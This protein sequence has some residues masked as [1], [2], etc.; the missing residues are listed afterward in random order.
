[1]LEFYPHYFEGWYA[2]GGN[3]AWMGLHLWYL[4]ILFLF[5]LLSLP[6]FLYLRQQPEQK[7]VTMLSVFCQKSGAIFLMAVP[8]AILEIVLDPK[9]LGFRSFGGWNLFAYLIFLY[10]GYLIAAREP[11][12]R[13]L[14]QNGAIALF[15]AVI[16]ALSMSFGQN[17]AGDRSWIYAGA[18]AL[19]AFNAWC[20]LVA[21]LYLG[22]KYLSFT[23]PIL[24]YSSEATLPVYML[25]Q[26]VIVVLGFYLAQWELSI[27]S[28]FLLLST[29]SA[30][31]IALLYEVFIR[32]INGLRFLFGLKPQQHS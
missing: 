11:I 4:L 8:I 10:Y 30:I 27:F 32:R 5:S 12:E 15:F 13:S 24:K 22:K 23:H 16:T 29:T 17:L 19:R 9:G 21:L 28:K 26:T 6:L 7:L 18:M 2:F 20:W 1:L 3:F 25:H 14:H 31:A